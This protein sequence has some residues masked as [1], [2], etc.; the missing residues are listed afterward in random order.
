M[1]AE[2]YTFQEQVQYLKAHEA[3]IL[4][5]L[6]R[7]YVYDRLLEPAK[8][9]IMSAYQNLIALAALS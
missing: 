6:T 8:L 3:T 9:G 4:I 5:L 2:W 7:Y 1:Y